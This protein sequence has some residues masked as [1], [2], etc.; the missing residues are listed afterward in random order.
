MQ[1]LVR[2]VRFSVNPFLPEDAI[3]FNSYCSKPCGE[4][5]AVFFEL[6]VGVVGAVEADTGFVINVSEIDKAVREFMVPIFAKQLREDFG[7]K[8]HISLVKLTELLK[9]AKENLKG[10]LGGVFLAELGLKLNPFRR[11]AMDCEDEKMIYFSE[12]FE[13]ASMH[14]LWNDEFSEEKNFEAFGK[15][16]NPAGHGH[17]YVIEVTVKSPANSGLSM[18]DFEMI[19]ENEFISQVD[20]KNLNADVEHFGKVNPTVENLAAFAWGNIEGKFGEAKLHAVT[21]WE[22]DRT[23]CTYYG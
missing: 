7:N 20:H 12:K 15:C 10:K 1:K 13:F 11:M 5:L 8:R 2:K 17:N 21:V 4:G 18:N 16:A 22:N 9:L 3:G 14:K 6:E 19:V 23:Y